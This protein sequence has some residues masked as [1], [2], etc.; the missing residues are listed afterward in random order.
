VIKKITKEYIQFTDPQFTYELFTSTCITT[1]GIDDDLQSEETESRELTPLENEICEFLQSTKETFG[2]LDFDIR[3]STIKET[4]NRAGIPSLYIN[5]REKQVCPF[6]GRCHSRKTNPVYVELNGRGAALRCFDEDCIVKRFPELGI[7][8]PFSRF[9]I[10]NEK[11]G[12]YNTKISGDLGDE[13][14]FMLMSSLSGTHFNIAKVLYHVYKSRFMV[15]DVRN[16][17][18]YEFE[19]SRGKWKRS[20]NMNILVSEEFAD[21]YR[22]LKTENGD[23]SAPFNEHIDRLVNKLESVTFKTSVLNEAKYLFYQSNPRF[24]EHLDANP[25]LIGFEN[26]VYDIKAGKFRQGT[27]EDYITFSTGY[28]WC[29]YDPDHPDTIGIYKFLSEILPNEAVRE[30]TL[31]ILGRSLIG[32]PDEKFYIWTGLSGANGKSTL[33]NFLEM[34]LGDYATSQDVALLTNKRAASNAATPEIIDIKGKR[35]VFFQEPEP[36]DRLRTGILKQFTGGDTIRARELY[37]KPISFR[38]MSNFFMC[39]NDLP[40]VSALDGGT[41][42]RIRV[43]EFT[44]RFCDDPK[45]PNEFRI[46]PQLKWKLE[47]WKPRFMSILIHYYHK[48]AGSGIKL[49]EPPEVNAATARYKTDNDKYNDFFEECLEESTAAFSTTLELFSAFEFW[50]KG[51]YLNEKMPSKSE[52]KMALRNKYGEELVRTDSTTNRKSKGFPVAIRG[53]DDEPFRGDELS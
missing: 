27:Y 6:K 2:E 12:S 41:W 30:W 32:F 37:K 25:Y 28:N 29:D 16:A 8:I 33:V 43:T 31:G 50:W 39:C 13:L 4:T 45:K 24:V 52:F 26:G 3:S 34:T 18:W 35:M 19:E 53:D 47:E 22:S 7:P 44:S 38:S 36:T 20:Y 17:D 1:L 48:Y 49:V 9:P 10:L 51:N 23:T 21:Y 42:R 14:N 11:L 46:D 15:D 5:P 40:H